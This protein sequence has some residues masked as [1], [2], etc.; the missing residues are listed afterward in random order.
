MPKEL[1]Y[2]VLYLV[3]EF[4]PDRSRLNLAMVNK[5]AFQIIYPVHL[6]SNFVKYNTGNTDQLL[7][8][9]S[10]YWWSL[11]NDK[12]E[13]LNKIFDYAGDDLLLECFSSESSDGKEDQATRGPTELMDRTVFNC[14]YAGKMT[15]LNILL[16]RFPEVV[17]RELLRWGHIWVHKA[18]D[19]SRSDFLQMLHQ[20]GWPD[21]KPENDNDFRY[22]DGYI[23]SARYGSVFRVLV[24]MGANPF[25]VYG[26]IGVLESRVKY[27]GTCDVDLLAAL[28]EHGADLE[29][30]S[31]FNPAIDIKHPFR[32]TPLD[33]A[34]KQKDHRMVEKLLSIGAHVGGSLRAYCLQ[35]D[36][37]DDFATDLWDPTTPLHKFWRSR[38][39]PGSPMI[40]TFG[41]C[42]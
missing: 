9:A 42:H 28:V 1:S 37:S 41:A 18:L 22:L 4:L 40:K 35:R 6:R 19:L 11:K 10:A 25:F 13:V 31:T 3:S 14:I 33:L 23:C 30:L 16:S 20:A 34:C 38:P 21:R 5:T 39:A 26:P 2:D 32:L 29:E 17:T 36:E 15:T 27:T 12:S 8:R 24:Q 7:M